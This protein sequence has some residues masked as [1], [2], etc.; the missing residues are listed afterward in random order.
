MLGRS[1][2]LRDD[3]EPIALQHHILD[4]SDEMR[5]QDDEL[6]RV[7]SNPLVDGPGDG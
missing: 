7:A 1:L 3:E 4:V 5:G 2:A 6:A